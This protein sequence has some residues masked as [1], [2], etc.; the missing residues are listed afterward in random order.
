MNTSVPRSPRLWIVIPCFNE[1]STAGNCILQTSPA[2]LEELTALINSEEIDAHSKICY[3]DDGSTDNTWSLIQS[4]SK[5]NPCIEGI[6]LSRNRGHQHALLAGLME[7]KNQ[8]DVAVSMDCDGQ[9]DIHAVE[10]MIAAYKAGNDVVYGVRS[11][12]E[13]DTAFKR[14]TAE[15]FYKLLNALGAEVVFN[16]A[17][18][19]LLSARALEGLAQFKEVNLFLR[20]MVPLVG[21]PSAIVEYSRTERAAGKS[22]YSLKKML[23]LGAN[24]ITSLS[25]KPIRFVSALGILVSLFGLVGVIWAIA[26]AVT[27]Q[28][29]A[30]WA[31]TICVVSLIG[32]VQ[33]L[34]IGIIGEYIGKIYLEVKERPRYL[35]AER[36]WAEQTTCSAERNGHPSP[37]NAQEN[38][39]A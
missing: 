10:K 24:G 36:T 13:T 9:D 27:G 19:R 25:T 38:F 30:G 7:A 5:D 12:R 20:G 35:I 14:V 3:V 15:A 26:S 23:S 17:D 29:V 11:S 31:S 37:L 8:C 39:P 21:Y 33:T 28:A 22:H 16:H 2:F 6:Q 34:C 32:G 1:G 18:Y 4:L